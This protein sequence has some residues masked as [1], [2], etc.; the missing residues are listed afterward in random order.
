[1]DN[2]RFC[3]V[4]DTLTRAEQDFEARCE[5]DEKLTRLSFHLRAAFD[6]CHEVGK[7]WTCIMANALKDMFEE[8]D[9]ERDA[10]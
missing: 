6:E 3:T 7:G 4:G 1:M 8:V 9:A 5:E 10:L 2:A